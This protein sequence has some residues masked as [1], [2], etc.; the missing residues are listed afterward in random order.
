M[1]RGKEPKI[2]IQIDKELANAIGSMEVAHQRRSAVGRN[3]KWA[4]PEIHH[5]GGGKNMP[6]LKG[7]IFFLVDI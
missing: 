1:G 6:C 5:A 2:A 4:G 7:L 3:Q